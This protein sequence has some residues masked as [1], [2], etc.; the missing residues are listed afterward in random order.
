MRFR[1]VEVKSRAPRSVGTR[2]GGVVNLTEACC[3]GHTSGMDDHGDP[4]QERRAT[5]RETDLAHFSHTH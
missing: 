2:Q 1:V 5:T 4:Q 3:G